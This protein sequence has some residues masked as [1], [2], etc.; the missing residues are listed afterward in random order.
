M[1]GFVRGDAELCARFVGEDRRRARRDQDNVG[2]DA[3]AGDLDRVRIDEDGARLGQRDA[4]LRQQLL[5]DAVE[6]VDLLVLAGDQRR[7][8]EARALDGPAEVA[9]ILEVLVEVRGIDQQLLR[10]ATPDHAGAADAIFLG[11]C[12]LGPITGRDARRP[13]AARA[14]ADDEEV[15]VVASHRILLQAAGWSARVWAAQRRCSRTATRITSSSGA[16]TTVTGL[17]PMP[18]RNRGNSAPAPDAMAKPPQTP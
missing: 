1:E 3:L 5:V 4:G 6:A 12:D 10:H 18:G 8:V 11:D 13:H 16:T 14:G 9:G 7:P 17:L 15:V 2:G